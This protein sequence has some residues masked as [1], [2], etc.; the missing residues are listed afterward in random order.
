MCHPISW[1]VFLA[2]DPETNQLQH[3][4]RALHEQRQPVSKPMWLMLA[5]DRPA[6]GSARHGRPSELSSSCARTR[7][8]LE[9]RYLTAS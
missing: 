1:D 8:T 9:K 4:A 2:D 6:T 3:K 7:A 5:R